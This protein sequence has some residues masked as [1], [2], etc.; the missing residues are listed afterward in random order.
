MLLLLH[1]GFRW[2]RQ[3]LVVN[4]QGRACTQRVYPKLALVTV[5]LPD[6]AFL[7]GWEPNRGS[8]MGN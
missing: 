8:S 5:E 6:E 4:E 2:D 7:D 1:S 3:W